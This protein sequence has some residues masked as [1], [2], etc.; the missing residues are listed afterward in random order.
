MVLHEITYPPYEKRVV[1]P[2]E[3]REWEEERFRHHIDCCGYGFLVD[4]Y[5]E[6]NDVEF[7]PLR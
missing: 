3:L 6:D 4:Q 7:A 5:I 1:D 2:A